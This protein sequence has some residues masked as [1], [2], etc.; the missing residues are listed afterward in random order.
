MRTKTS[1][2]TVLIFFMALGMLPAAGQTQG[3][4]QNRE[5]FRGS[6]APGETVVG[7]VTS[8]SK[9]SLV[10][11]PLTGGAPVTVKVGDNTRISKDRQPIK[12]EEIKTDEMVFARGELKDNVMQAAGVGVVNPQMIQRFGQG[13]PGPGG[14]GAGPG[15]GANFNRED[16]G[17]KFIL[18]EVKAI[19]ETKLTIARPD[20]ESQDIEVDENTSFKRGTESITLPD[21]KTGDFVRGAGEVKNGVFVPKELNVGRGQ[22]RVFTNGPG[23]APSQ[24]APSDKPSTPP[25]PKN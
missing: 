14:F 10:V 7:K 5:R 23:A 2:L 13:G 9:D 11:A 15:G 24:G 18:G 1:F 4:E 6:Q 25:P 22:M 21:I 19:N 17:K 3:S 12:L 8:V 16:L 20:G